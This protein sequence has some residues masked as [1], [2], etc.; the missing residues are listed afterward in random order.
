MAAGA[1]LLMVPTRLLPMN[2]SQG[3]AV[4]QIVALVIFL[5][6]AVLL[7]TKN[8][9]SLALHQIASWPRG[10][11]LAAGLG[12]LMCMPWAAL[13][14]LGS[15]LDLVL[16][17]MTVNIMRDRRGGAAASRLFLP[18]RN[19]AVLGAGFGRPTGVGDFIVLDWD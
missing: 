13:G 15:A 10:L 12:A 1:A 18:K 6:G 19:R 11:F 8:R 7:S 17:G 16:G 9:E 4:L 2:D 5:V 3:V 14:A